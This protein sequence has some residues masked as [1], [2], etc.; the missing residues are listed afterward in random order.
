MRNILI[1]LALSLVHVPAMA[2]DYT[3]GFLGVQS[4]VYTATGFLKTDMIPDIKFQSLRRL[5]GDVLSAE[6]RAAVLGFPVTAKARL[7]IVFTSESSFELLDLD[8]DSAVAGQGICD[9]SGCT[10]DVRVMEGG[11]ELHEKWVPVAG[12]F[13]V[14]EASQTAFGLHSTYVASFSLR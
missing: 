1:L 10:F 13:E 4:G 8:Q 7:R 14:I 2:A 5:N 6:T 3:R 12:G 9:P 11:L